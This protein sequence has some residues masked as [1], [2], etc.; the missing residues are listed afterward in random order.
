MPRMMPTLNE[1][2]ADGL[3]K[4]D[5]LKAKCVRLHR[6]YGL[7]PI[8]LAKRFGWSSDVVTQILRKAGCNVTARG[9]ARRITRSQV[10]RMVELALAGRNQRQ[11]AN[12]LG[13]GANTV[14]RYLRRH[15]IKAAPGG[16]G[17]SGGS[18]NRLFDPRQQRASSSK[19]TEP[20][21]FDY[22]DPETAALAE[23]DDAARTIQHTMTYGV[24][25]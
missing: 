8:V 3:L 18:H 12:E 10:A 20:D 17:W 25:T 2:L 1:L 5:E 7:E 19:R 16:R 14:A 11:I 21:D 22:D 15:G 23:A 9:R 4:T 24:Q 6:Q 13:L